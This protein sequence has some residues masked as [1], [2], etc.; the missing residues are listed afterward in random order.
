MPIL[1]SATIFAS[2]T[3]VSRIFGFVRD[4]LLAITLGAT[5]IAD[6]FIFA[7]RFPHLFRAILAEG[8]M[9]SS[10]I[11]V[12]EKRRQQ[13]SKETAHA[14]AAPAATEFAALTLKMLLATTILIAIVM[15][16]LMPQIVALLAA[17]FVQIKQKYNFAV[18]LSRIAIFYLP[19]IATTALLCAILSAHGFF[20][21][22]GA[23]PA[24][25]NISL[26]IV[27]LPAAIIMISP[28]TIATTLL[29]ALLLAG[30]LQC[31][32]AFLACRK[33]NAAP[34]THINSNINKNKIKQLVKKDRKNFLILF[35]AAI[36]GHSL[37]QITF[38]VNQYFASKMAEGTIASLYYA[39]RLMQLPIGIIAVAS[40]NVLLP[41]IARLRALRQKKKLMQTQNQVFAIILALAIPCAVGL[42]SLAE[43]IVFT[44]F[45]YGAFETNDRIR[46]AKILAILAIALPPFI[47]MRPLLAVLFAFQKPRS[48]LILAT[49]SLSINLILVYKLVA[50]FGYLGI[51]I[52]VAVA[53]WANLIATATLV[54]SKGYWKVSLNFSIQTLKILIA[55]ACLWLA[56]QLALSIANQ[57]SLLDA[58]MPA[59]LR[60]AILVMMIVVPSAIY[61]ITIIA[62]KTF[63]LNELYKWFKKAK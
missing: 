50:I 56:L 8:A 15:M 6:A 19:L 42:A 2:W 55:A 40:A 38:L 17:G 52:A 5:N 46:A 43:W 9:T 34:I 36:G 30:T 24:I 23:M 16:F 53:A 12:Y 58:H 62:T 18:D 32:L 13:K 22:Y 48:V 10:F 44:L 14:A 41:E 59:L 31:A 27:L 4:I 26:I 28:I 63:K 54:I 3:I 35:A 20:A 61:I 7:Y 29:Y 51:P 47:M 45:E 49:L 25:L 11:P 33:I 37:V 39:E 57:A 21:L 1:R 60:A